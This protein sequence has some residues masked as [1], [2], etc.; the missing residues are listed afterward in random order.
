MAYKDNDVKTCVCNNKMIGEKT[1]I[2]KG[3]INKK[4]VEVV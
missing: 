1:S 3:Q 4:L 2:R